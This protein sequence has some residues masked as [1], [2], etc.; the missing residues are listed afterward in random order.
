MAGALVGGAFLSAF[1]QM[2]FDRLASP[3]I[4]NYFQERKI[5]VRLLRKLNITLTSINAVLDDA[6]ENQIQNPHVKKWVDELKDAVFDAEDLLDDIETEVSQ[7]KLEA[8]LHATLSK[9]KET[10]LFM[11]RLKNLQTLTYFK[12]GKC[13]GF[14]V[15]QLGQL[16]QLGGSVSIIGLQNVIDRMDGIAANLKEKEYIEELELQWSGEDEDE[17]SEKGRNVL[18]SLKP[19]KNLKKLSVINY[20]GT[21]FPEWFGDCYSLPKI[22]SLELRNCKYFFSL[23]STWTGTL[24]QRTFAFLGLMHWRQLVLSSTFTVGSDD[25]LSSS[26]TPQ[27]FRSLKILRLKDMKSRE[28]WCCFIEGE[29]EAAGMPFSCLKELVIDN[30]P[31]HNTCLHSFLH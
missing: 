17:D 21:R 13:S 8:E 20:G 9:I 7:Q 4:L 2:A 10:P 15:K 18:E 29:I 30:C 3:K 24:S 11:G 6:E 22:V 25:S 31:R 27:P 5:N 26:V 1:V 14:D 28:E 12:V 16:N 19:H 23:P